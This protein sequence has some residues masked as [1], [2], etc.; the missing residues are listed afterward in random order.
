MISTNIVPLPKATLVSTW[1]TKKDP[2]L[3]F[4]IVEA[5]SRRAKERGI[6]DISMAE[7][8]SELRISTKTLYKV[9]SNKRELVQ[10]L[11]ARW[12]LRIRKPIEKYQG[13][14]LTVL[15]YWVKVWVENDA[16][17]STQFWVDL[18]SDFPDLYKI[19]VDSLYNRMGAMKKR[20]TPFLKP[21]V[22]AEFAWSSYF[23]LMTASAQAKTYEKIGMTKEQCV[24]EA[25]DFW[26]SAAID[27]DRLMQ[28]SEKTAIGSNNA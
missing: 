2:E 9:F 3:A 5:F 12:E 14:L 22:N 18:K 27:M 20:L 1:E 10:V 23:I 16:Q 7:I 26:M 28:A 24:F 13:D 17:F 19:Y 4:S 11:V 8:A 21:E 25:F 15:K 6:R